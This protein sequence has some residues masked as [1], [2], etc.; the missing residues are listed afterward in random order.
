MRL[1]LQLGESIIHSAF[2]AYEFE[3]DAAY[4]NSLMNELLT[5]NAALLKQ[6]DLNPFSP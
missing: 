3:R 5:R 6:T 4:L 1:L 2:I